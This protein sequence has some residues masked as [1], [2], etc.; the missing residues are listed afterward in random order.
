MLRGTAIPVLNVA[1]L[2]PQTDR[3]SIWSAK[4]VRLVC[5]VR[6]IRSLSSRNI[7]DTRSAGEVVAARPEHRILAVVMG[8]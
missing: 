2:P 4:I 6:G 1:A 7:D 3:A 5:A 8:G